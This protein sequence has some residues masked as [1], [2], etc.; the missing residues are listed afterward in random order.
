MLKATES[1]RRQ[2]GPR[3]EGILLVYGERQSRRK[4]TDKICVD[5]GWSPQ[6]IVEAKRN[7]YYVVQAMAS[8][9]PRFPFQNGDAFPIMSK[10]SSALPNLGRFWTIA[11]TLSFSRLVL[12]VPI[13]V[14]LWRD[15]PLGW[16]L[17]LTVV[18]IFTD[19]IDGRVARWTRTVSE[20]G[21][22]IDPVA[23]KVAAVLTV[24]VLTFRPAEPQLPLWFFG[25]IV[26]RD[27]LILTGGAW[28]ARRSG[29]VLMSAWAGKAASLWLALTVLSVILEAD[30]PVLTVCLWM[31][32][33]LF[34][35]SFGVYVVRYLNAVRRSPPPRD[36]SGTDAAPDA[37]AESRTRDAVAPT[38]SSAMTAP[39]LGRIQSL[40]RPVPPSHY[41]PDRFT[42]R[43]EPSLDSTFRP[44]LRNLFG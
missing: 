10:F 27:L 20:W 42:F 18:A 29:K 4:R 8:T 44:P 38:D 9:P 24:S 3:G 23:D 30:V 33:G 41:L 1:A 37:P 34:V 31:T 19:W 35:F 13:A 39:G 26:G 6:R 14:L 32:T 2:E 17:G 36:R 16:L 12:V 25:V 21:K 11:N 7:L 43:P 40:C 22:V 28:I 5:S 15:G